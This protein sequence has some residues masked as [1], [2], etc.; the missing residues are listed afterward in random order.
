MAKQKTKDVQASILR[1]FRDL[2]LWYWR[3]RYAPRKYIFPNQGSFPDIISLQDEGILTASDQR[4]LWMRQVPQYWPRRLLHIQG[5]NL[6]S[7]ERTG[8]STYGSFEAPPYNVLTYT[9]GRFEAK[10][11]EA[12]DAV[13]IQNVP[14][15]IPRIKPEHFGVDDFRAVIKRVLRGCSHIWLDIACIHQE[16]D[17]EKMDEIGHQA[18]IFDRA[19]HCYVWLR[20]TNS[21]LLQSVYDVFQSWDQ[22]QDWFVDQ[23]NSQRGVENL[24]S[25][26][27]SLSNFFS[28]PWFT[29]LWTL[30]EAFLRPD[31]FVVT[32]DNGIPLIDGKRCRLHHILSDCWNWIN[33]LD[34]LIR[35]DRLPIDRVEYIRGLVSLVEH[36]GV[37]VLSTGSPM[38]LYA[39]SANKTPRD[40]LDKIYGI[41]QVFGLSLGASI[42]PHRTW[43]LPELED[44]LGASLNEADPVTAQAF[45]HLTD[46]PSLR[47]WRVSPKIWVDE[48]RLGL[49][50]PRSLC[51]ISFAEDASQALFDGPVARFTDFANFWRQASADRAT[52]KGLD[53]YFDL[54]EKNRMHLPAEYLDTTLR[55][56][57]WGKFSGDNG[58]GNINEM[59]ANL[60]QMYGSTLCLLLVGQGVRSYSFDPDRLTTYLGVFVAPQK[61]QGSETVWVRFGICLWEVVTD[62]MDQRQPHLF[63]RRSLQLG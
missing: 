62:I 30:Q 3:V 60:S 59:V 5:D 41:M 37:R 15:A 13:G 11:G 44:Q 46:P 58:V 10:P 7:V 25:W 49:Q 17:D 19:E 52:W 48:S 6:V 43:T 8:T 21:E 40:P 29:S 1:K 23:L 26:H 55:W 51:T 27:D 14:W 53:V 42:Q 28:D 61:L 12:G 50:D 20:H 54:T 33:R 47:S 16:D 9:W 22:T 57:G 56:P 35:L 36:Y 18:A 63:Q 4:R 31:S 39:V 38:G 34:R 45:V 2:R 24:Q 32:R